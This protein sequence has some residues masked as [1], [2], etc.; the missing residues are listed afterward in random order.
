MFFVLKV[1]HVVSNTIILLLHVKLQQG[2]NSKEIEMVLPPDTK[3][4]V[5]KIRVQN[6]MKILPINIL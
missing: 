3:F 6:G 2:E 1:L 4:E 5:G